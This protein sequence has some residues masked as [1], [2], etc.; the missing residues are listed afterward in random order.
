MTTQWLEADAW[1]ASVIQNL[2]DLSDEELL[3]AGCHAGDDAL[4]DADNTHESHSI[5]DAV[6]KRYLQHDVPTQAAPT[7]TSLSDAGSVSDAIPT[8]KP[9][10]K[11]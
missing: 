7:C 1:L 9:A 5:S 8:Q 3:E 11:S 4:A 6:V 10:K 2:H